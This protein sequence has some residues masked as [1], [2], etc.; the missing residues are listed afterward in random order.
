MK[1]GQVGWPFASCA[2]NA[3]VVCA[4]AAVPAGPEPVERYC[5]VGQD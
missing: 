4:A 1:N 3:Y 2:T 5:P